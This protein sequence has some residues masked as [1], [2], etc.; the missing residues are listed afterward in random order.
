MK[1]MTGMV[2]NQNNN[3]GDKIKYAFT[4]VKTEDGATGLGDSFNLNGIEFKVED[5]PAPAIRA[6]LQDILNLVND[7]IVLETV[8]SYLSQFE[9]GEV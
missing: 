5:I 1:K 6:M 4:I 7:Q 2:S 9:Q 3:K 8:N